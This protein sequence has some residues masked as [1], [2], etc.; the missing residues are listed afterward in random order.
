MESKDL[1]FEQMIELAK[2]VWISNCERL[3][4]GATRA[5]VIVMMSRLYKKIL[6]TINND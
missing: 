4:D 6:K 3:E 1:E 2:K 5:E